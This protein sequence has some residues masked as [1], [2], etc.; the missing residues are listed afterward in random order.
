[1]S[2]RFVMVLLML[3]LLVLLLVVIELKKCLRISNDRLRLT[4]D[5]PKLQEPHMPEQKLKL[6]K[7]TLTDIQPH[8][9]LSV[10]NNSQRITTLR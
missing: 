5:P 6:L 9:S 1:M 4:K 3:S 10:P 2:G 7:T 8:L